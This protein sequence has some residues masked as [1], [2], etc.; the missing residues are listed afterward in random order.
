MGGSELDIH[1]KAANLGFLG[2]I[3]LFL[4]FVGLR[5]LEKSYLSAP[6]S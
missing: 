6:F 1:S 2:F 3:G 5:S 4:G